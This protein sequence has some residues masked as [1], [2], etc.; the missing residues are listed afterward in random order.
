M[1][2]Q[3]I[4]FGILALVALAAA[5]PAQTTTV[6][7]PDNVTAGASNAFPWNTQGTPVAPNTGYTTVQIYPASVLAAQGAL[8]GQKLSGLAFIPVTG[9][10]SMIQP[11]CRVYVGHA[12]ATTGPTLWINNMVAPETIW[13]TSVDGPLSVPGWAA[14]V[15]APIPFR[16]VTNFFWNGVSDI[17]LMVSHAGGWTG[18]YSVQSAP[19][20]G[21]TRHGTTQFLPP[22]G[23]AQTTT[24]VLAPR[25]RMILD[26]IST[27]AATTSGGG[28]GD[29]NLNPPAIGANMIEGY[30]LLSAT[31]AAGLGAGSFFGINPDFLT[32]TFIQ[33][34]AS[35]GN[36]LHWLAPAPAGFYPAAPFTLLAGTMTPFAG[37]TWDFVS[38][39]FAA[40]FSAY[41]VSCV[42]RVTF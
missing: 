15:W 17:V 19:A 41:E 29:F 30:T 35:F 26:C 10:G 23:T 16:P 40:G 11:N 20:P 34:P 22:P 28:V 18:S 12:A 7:F 38:V 42:S 14:N 21:Y 3:R 25:C 8:P 6:Y 33:T 4:V 2:T 37:Q 36:P 27:F 39:A 32:F 5:V 13:D 31:T 24:G 1:N 9:A